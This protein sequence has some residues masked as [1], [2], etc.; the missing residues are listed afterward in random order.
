MKIKNRQLDL[1]AQELIDLGF[2]QKIGISVSYVKKTI[3]GYFEF[4]ALEKEYR[5]YHVTIIGNSKNH[6][7][8]DIQSIEE[9]ELVLKVFKISKLKE[10]ITH[11]GQEDIFRSC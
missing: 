6:L 11:N 2:K 9:L 10:L 8:L 4:N 1:T 5:W 3:N 7:H